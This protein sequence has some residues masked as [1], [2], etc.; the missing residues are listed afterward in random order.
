M[1]KI[2]TAAIISLIFISGC[3]KDTDKNSNINFSELQSDLVSNSE[4]KSAQIEDLKDIKISQKYGIATDDIEEGFVYLTKDEKPDRIIL[5]KTKGGSSA[6]N[7][8]KSLANEISGLISS[9]ENDPGESKKLEEHVLKTKDNY[10][11]LIVSE[12]S[13]KLEDRFD[14]FFQ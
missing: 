10:V 9:W 3:G 12:N 6:E 8:E 11:I 13:A 2:I 1:L 14:N 5:V 7:I 4:F